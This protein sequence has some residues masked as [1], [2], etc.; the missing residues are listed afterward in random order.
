MGNFQI[1][2]SQFTHIKTQCRERE[3]ERR[4]EM[5]RQRERMRR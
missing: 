1:L 3:R 2:N 4:K 5:G